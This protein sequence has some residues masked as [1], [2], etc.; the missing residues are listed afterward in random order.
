ME[1]FTDGALKVPLY[2]IHAI[3]LAGLSFFFTP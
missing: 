3:W 1:G 2:D